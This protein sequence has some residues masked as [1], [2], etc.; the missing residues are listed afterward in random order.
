MRNFD[1]LSFDDVKDQGIAFTLAY[2]LGILAHRAAQ[3]WRSALR[4][5]DQDAFE[6]HGEPLATHPVRAP[7]RDMRD[8]L[9][10]L[11]A[12]D[13]DATH[14]LHERMPLIPSR[15]AEAMEDEGLI[16]IETGRTSSERYSS[17]SVRVTTL[18]REMRWRLGHG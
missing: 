13:P 15:L 5:L 9:R 11:R 2:G 6:R 14:I 1:A 8:R 18:G 3:G 7:T 4:Q 12:R 16:F 17:R 10:W